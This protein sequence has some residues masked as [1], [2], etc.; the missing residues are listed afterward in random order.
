MK[1]TTPR[2]T[3]FTKRVITGCSLLLFLLTVNTSFA[4]EETKE[5]KETTEKI[6]EPKPTKEAANIRFGLKIMPSLNWYSPDKTAKYTSNGT[7][8][9]FGWGLT[10]E[11]KIT[12]TA[13]FVW[14]LEMRYDKGDINYIDSTYYLVHN[15]EFINIED[16][17]GKA[18]TTYL[19]KNRKHN[20][21]YI[22]IPLMLKLKTSEIGYMTY[23]GELGVLTQF[24]LK[25]KATDEVNDFG[26]TNDISRE[27]IT[28]SE[29][30]NLVKFNFAVGGGLEWNMSGSTAVTLAIHYN[31]GLSN[32]YKK[33]SEYLYSNSAEK[34]KQ[35]ATGNNVAISIGMLF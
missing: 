3:N 13:S 25:G 12:K 19:L 8:L 22:T 5:K 32:V 29:E 30:M 31:F 33:E 2:T 11:N 14:G 24:K 16:T 18:Y 6:E 26:N 21:N 10:I 7:N 23:Y 17:A 34:I 27:D 4:Q 28:I 35:N 20:T 1:Y 15:D 9:G